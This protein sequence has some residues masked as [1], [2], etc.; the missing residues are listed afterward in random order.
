M[1]GEYILGFQVKPE[2][3]LENTCKTIQA[4]LNAFQSSPV[5]GVQYSR[6]DVGGMSGDVF[7]EPPSILQETEEK[8][9]LEKPLRVDAFAAYFSDGPINGSEPR[10]IVYSE[11]L[12]VA[13]E[14]LKPGFTISD[15]W[16]INLD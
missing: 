3:R 14:Q 10:A 7:T 13:I 6:Q 9:P 2:E 11:E 5:F 12:G 15:L 1:S 4:L 16:E 8:E